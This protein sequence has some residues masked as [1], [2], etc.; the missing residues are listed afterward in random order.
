MQP[1]ARG[2]KTDVRTKP[3][4]GLQYSDQ[5]F[6]DGSRRRVLA[7]GRQAKLPPYRY[8]ADGLATIHEPGFL[9]DARFRAAYEAGARTGHRICAPENLHIEWRVHTCCWAASHAAKLPGD[10]VE[11]GVSTGIVSLAVCRYTGFENL[12]KTFW[13]FDTYEGIPESQAAPAEAPLTRSKNERLYFDSHALVA[14]HF[15]DYA[16]VKLV[17]GRVPESLATVAI[18]AIAYLH[19]D[20]NIAYPELEASKALWDRVSPGGM[21]VYDDY[22]SPS[23]GAQKQ[24]IDAFAA[25][26]AVSVL[27]LPT[28][29][30]LIVKPPA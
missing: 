20:M 26:R 17:R 4:S 15:A 25:E 30:G 12:R 22:G 19:I 18:D 29:Q 6:R 8:D 3:E 2:A 1:P 28:G 5:V 13:L 24:A 14:G 23:H 11:C 27:S 9:S 7:D 16:N 10:F 21:V